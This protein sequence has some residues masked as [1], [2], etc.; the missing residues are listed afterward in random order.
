MKMNKI[1]DSIPVPREL[2]GENCGLD[3]GDWNRFIFYKSIM[4]S[5][6]TKS[7]TKTRAKKTSA[8]KTRAKK[9]RAKKSAMKT[10]YKSRKKS[11]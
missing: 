3:I 6:D 1:E 2:I 4:K 7:A 8:K 10:R 9:T 11:K 5:G